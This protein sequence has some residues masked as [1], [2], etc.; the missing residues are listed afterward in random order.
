M[1]EDSTFESTG[2]IR[3]RSRRWMA[4]TLA[5]NGSILL[6][7]ILI[8]LIYPEALSM[9]GRFVLMEAP[10]PPPAQLPKQQPRLTNAIVVQPNTA[11]PFEAPVKIPK[12][13][14]IADKPE[15]IASSGPIDWGPST[16]SG[17]GS[18]SPFSR[19]ANQ[20]VV[21]PAATGPVRLPS[22]FA[23]GL[24][25]RKTIPVYPA[26]AKAAGIQG[27]VVLEATISKGGAITN[28][29]VISGQAMLQQAAMDAVAQWQYRPYLLNGQPIEV[30]TT[31]NVIFTL[32]R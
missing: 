1:F 31:V 18:D 27:T 13:I 6:A 3:T 19:T 20:P 28:L 24:L 32:G 9:H 17:I 5:L 16:G 14:L 2:R 22:S 7:L 25:I 10:P 4:V 8:P 23:S 15:V 11:N 26:I 21:K 30:E 29:R 12:G